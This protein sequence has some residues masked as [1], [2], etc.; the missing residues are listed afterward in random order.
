MKDTRA[1]HTAFQYKPTGKRSIG[2]PKRRWIECLEDDLG[3]ARMSLR[4][5][6][7]GRERMTLLEIAE[8]RELWKD[9]MERSLTGHSRRTT[10]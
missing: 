1:A 4:G 9:V 5:K 8:R 3:K 6:T 10:T 7:T 2:R